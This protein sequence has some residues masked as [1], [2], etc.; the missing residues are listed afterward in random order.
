M[1]RIVI[2]VA[3]TMCCA[4][5]G[6]RDT[7]MRYVQITEKEVRMDITFLVAIESGG[8]NKCGM[9]EI[10]VFFELLYFSAA[11]GKIWLIRCV[12]YCLWRVFVVCDVRVWV[13]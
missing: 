1:G 5:V 7:V 4:T 10:L 9:T 12:F 8:D 2:W 13:A 11:G 6:A 3:A